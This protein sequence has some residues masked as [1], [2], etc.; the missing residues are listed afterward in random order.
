MP[1]SWWRSGLRRA[2]PGR[3]GLRNPDQ[4]R[5]VGDAFVGD[6][7][8]I[9][10]AA[11]ALRVAVKESELGALGVQVGMDVVLLGD[12]GEP[13]VVEQPDGQGRLGN[14]GKSRLVACAGAIDVFVEA[15]MEEVVAVAA[16]GIGG[17]DPGRAAG[18]HAGVRAP[19]HFPV[20]AQSDDARQINIPALV[21]GR[22]VG[23]AI[24]GQ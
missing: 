23:A 22:A 8:P 14:P 16:A 19:G 20:R 5:I 15:I 24:F 13:A 6:E 4:V 11:E 3:S 7:V 12:A 2:R 10:A 18:L 17:A 1:F 9:L 21:N